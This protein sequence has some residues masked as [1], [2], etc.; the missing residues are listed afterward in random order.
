MMTAHENSKLDPVIAQFK[1]EMFLLCTGIANVANEI[2]QALPAWGP[3][4]TQPVNARFSFAETNAARLPDELALAVLQ[5]AGAHVHTIGRF[6]Q[7]EFTPPATVAPIARSAVE[8]AALLI[9][10]TRDESPEFRTVRAARAIRAGMNRDKAHKLKGLEDLY[11]NL[12]K[13]VTRY[14]TKN[15]IPDL[16]HDKV[17]YTE[18]VE[19]TLGELVGDEFYGELCSYTHHNTWK[20]FY[21][22]IAANENPTVLEVD[23]LYFAQKMALALAG[24]A[25]SILKYREPTQTAN[26]QELLNDKTTR[27]LRLGEEIQGYLEALASNRSD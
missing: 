24:A 15:E 13:L 14:T 8:N 21:Q 27:L 22:F 4:I 19:L 16:K 12:N 2:G 9:F 10:L 11:D 3:D 23:S 5:V 17:E 18:L 1:H 25:F 20:A 7:D 26:L 6:M